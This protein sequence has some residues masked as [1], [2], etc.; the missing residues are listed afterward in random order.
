MCELNKL[1]INNTVFVEMQRPIRTNIAA[2]K[3][4]TNQF[5]GQ[6]KPIIL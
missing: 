3:F 6:R 1:F 5:R 2:E 4:I